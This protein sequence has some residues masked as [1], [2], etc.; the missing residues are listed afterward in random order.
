MSTYSR[1]SKAI[2]AVILIVIMLVG[3]GYYVRQQPTTT[4]STSSSTSISGQAVPN[5]D[6][7]VE[8]RSVAP[9]EGGYDPARSWDDGA[10]PIMENVYETLVTWD[11]RNAS[12]FIPWLATSLPDVSPDGLVYTFHLRQGIMFQD[13]TPFNATAVKFSLDRAIL[14][15]V[16]DGS[17]FLIAPNETMA[18][19]GGPR[20]FNAE[21]V[22]NYNAT[23]AKIY[24]A[25][26]GVKVID[27]YTVQ[28]TLEHPYAAVIATMAFSVT[29]IVSP[30]YVTANCPGSAE[31]PG[32]MPGIPCDFMTNHAMGTGPWKLVEVTPKVRVV[33]ERFDGY[34]GGPNHTGPAKLKRYIVNY[35]TEVGTRELD[36]FSG[37]AD[38]IELR[39][40]NAFDIID[41]NAWLNNHQIVPL[42]PGIRVWTAPTIAIY[43]ITLN[44]RIKPLDNVLFRQGL[45]YAFD[46]NTYI[47]QALNGF[48]VRLDSLVPPGMFGYDPTVPSYTYDIAKAKALFQQVGYVG[49]L[50]I[51]VASGDTNSEAAALLLK[52]SM[53]QADP[54]VQIRISE[55]DTPTSLSLYHTFK[56][57]IRLGLW[58]QDLPDPAECVANFATQAGFRAKMSEFNNDTITSLVNRGASIT[59]PAQRLAIYHEIQ[60]EMYRKVPYIWLMT[61][62]A[63]NVERDWVLPGDNP[64]G[65]GLYNPAYNDGTGGLSG[66]YHPYGIWKANTTQ[67]IAVDIGGLPIANSLS[68]HSALTSSFSITQIADKGN[69]FAL[70]LTPTVNRYS[71]PS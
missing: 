62:I 56:L 24:L 41:K 53:S 11:G 36:L 42:R 30:S 57:P 17:Q 48:A 4:T 8:E 39:G 51:S 28:I 29:G 13:G 59:N 40:P 14:M 71:A 32:V 25:Q 12:N 69:S 63:I 64:I 34:W 45:S 6:T 21:T 70:T 27:L 1:H 23:E 10:N 2:V 60:T 38:T 31:M 16:A 26:N 19:K 46:Y 22:S 43:Q 65:R 52:D 18:I 9:G 35:V 5:P 58:T 67:Q 15:N 44:P 50:E 61:P 47:T 20:Y 37:T 54:A 68:M 33:L 55:V 7:L 3:I 49:T 66:G